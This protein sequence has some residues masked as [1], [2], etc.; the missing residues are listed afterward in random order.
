MCLMVKLVLA[1]HILF[2]KGGTHMGKND[3]WVQR[4]ADRADLHGESL[5]GVPVME[6][7]GDRRVL[8]ERHRGV[9]EY[10]AERICVLLCYGTLCICGGGLEL[11]RMTRDQLVISGRIDGISIRRRNC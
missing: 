2:S 10:S 1:N 5:P 11:I 7:A 9:T 8:I 3:H 4:L 6:L